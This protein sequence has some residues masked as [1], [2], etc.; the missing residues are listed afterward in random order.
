MK[1]LLLKGPG[2]ILLEELPVPQ[3]SDDEVLVETKYCGICGTDVHS[4][5]QA[6]KMKPGT[7]LG[8]EFSGII[9]AVGKRVNNWKPGD[10]VV[11]NRAYGMPI[12][13]HSLVE[14]SSWPNKNAMIE[15][16]NQAAAVES[17]ALA[18][19]QQNKGA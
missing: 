1:T 3:I 8:H 19:E 10:R 13:P 11:V 12:P 5:P 9:A 16:M 6:D 7:Y 18:A 17:E 4:V 14:T 2:E 15:S